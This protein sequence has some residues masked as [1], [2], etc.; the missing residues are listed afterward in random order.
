M[1]S[2]ERQSPFR[3]ALAYGVLGVAALV[4]GNVI[5]HY[6]GSRESVPAEVA[7]WG[8]GILAAIGAFKGL[9]KLAERQV[10][11]MRVEQADHMGEVWNDLPQM[12]DRLDLRH[13]AN[14]LHSLQ[15]D[16]DEIEGVDPAVISR[17]LSSTMLGVRMGAPREHLL[18]ECFR[19]DVTRAISDLADARAQMGGRGHGGYILDKGDDVLIMPDETTQLARFLDETAPLAVQA[20]LGETEPSWHRYLTG[21]ATEL[22]FAELLED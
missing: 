20:E 17:K 1:R 18:V 16:R 21:R 8:G 11:R 12:R 15:T 5:D 6:D 14:R 4:G 13:I 19:D 22:Q 2:K 7:K 9:N 3:T 10:V